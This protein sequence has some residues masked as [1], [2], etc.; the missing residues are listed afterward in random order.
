MTTLR[1]ALGFLSIRLSVSILL[2]LGLL[3]NHKS[4]EKISSVR[5]GYW[6]YL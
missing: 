6:Y 5:T 2:A 3:R 4:G 1:I